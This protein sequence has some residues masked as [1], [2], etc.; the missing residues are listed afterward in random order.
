MKNQ[1][2]KKISLLSLL[3][4]LPIYYASNS[5]IKTSPEYKSDVHINRTV[6]VY[7]KEPIMK[8]IIL[9]RVPALQQFPE[10]PRGCEV[11]SLA[12]LLNFAGV[13]V[14]KLTL[15]DEIPKVPYFSDGYFGNP[16]QGFVGNMYTYNQPG[17]GVYHEVI[18]DLASQYLPGQ[19]DNLTGD[20]FSSVQKKLNAGKPVWVIVGSTFAFLPE[21]QWETWIT[22][23]GEINITRRM[24]SVLVTGYDENNVYFNDPFYPDQ[25]QS[26]NFE[27]FVTSWTQFGSQAIS[28]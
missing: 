24:H 17:L 8:E 26:A 7:Q 12:M 13:S 16:N 20:H 6:V 21:E 23:D 28:Y 4:I 9:L 1:Q 22:K 5:P 2:P 11:T 15:A 14:D 27:S 19:I 25:N 3:L 18:E 10:L